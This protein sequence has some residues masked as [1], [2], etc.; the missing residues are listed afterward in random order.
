[1]TSIMHKILLIL[2]LCFLQNQLSAQHVTMSDSVKNYLDQSF[3]ILEGKALNRSTV[4]WVNLKRDVYEKAQ[5][6]QT[7]ED[8]L[9]LYPYIF[10]QIKDHHGALVFKNKSYRWNSGDGPKENKIVVDAITKYKDVESRLIGDHIGYI[11]IPGNNDFSAQKMDEISKTIKEAISRINSKKIMGWIIDLRINTGGNM[12][13]MIGGITDLI[14]DGKLGGFITYDNQKDGEWIAKD[15]GLYVD[16]IKATDVKY[17]GLPI[18]QNLPIAVLIGG[19]TASSGE[20]TAISIK[21]RDKTILIGEPS[22]GYT[23][24]NKGFEINDYSGLNLAI[25]F[26]MDRN[27]IIYDQRLSPDIT[28]TGGDDFGNLQKDKKV[29]SAMLWIKQQ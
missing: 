13:P 26:A 29:L 9:P 2:T 8:L 11:L 22:A 14:G 3:S 28:I 10:E 1:M 6:A 25:E 17:L 27:G 7:Y 5:K 4:N 21:G 24:V 16:T 20:M 23:T 15:G 12:Y 18:K 19:Y